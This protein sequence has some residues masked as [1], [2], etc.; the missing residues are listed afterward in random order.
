MSPKE[1]A[2][3]PTEGIVDIVGQKA[4]RA[5]TDEEAKK[6]REENPDADVRVVNIKAGNW[7]NG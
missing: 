2:P 7:E 4:L 3:K 5:A 6:I 1:K